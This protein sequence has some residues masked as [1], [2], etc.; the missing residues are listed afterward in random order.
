MRHNV[1]NENMQ[2]VPG[3]AEPVNPAGGANARRYR[4]IH[5]RA[6]GRATRR[7]KERFLAGPTEAFRCG[8]T[9]GRGWGSGRRAPGTTTGRIIRRAH[10][11][12]ASQHPRGGGNVRGRRR[13]SS[14][15]GTTMLHLSFFCL[16]RSVWTR[17][18]KVFM[19]VRSLDSSCWARFAAA[20]SLAGADAG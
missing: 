15:P 13:R 1:R 3:T 7:R 8:S 6:A 20:C 19:F 18:T 11:S 17:S 5:L 9:K 10:R 4:G 14:A 2:G 16:L 12:F